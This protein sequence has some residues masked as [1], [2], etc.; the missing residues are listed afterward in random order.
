[1]NFDTLM[2]AKFRAADVFF[3]KVALLVRLKFRIMIT[4]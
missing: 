3:L 4:E 1:M 2:L